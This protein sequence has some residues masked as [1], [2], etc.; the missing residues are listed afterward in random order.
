ME[1]GADGRYLPRHG[2]YQTRLYHIWE[3]M[4]ARCD[5]PSCNGYEYYGAKGISY[6]SRWGSF[7]NFYEDMGPSYR[8]GLSLERV[9]ILGNYT[10]DNCEWVSKKE[11]SYNKSSSVLVTIDGITLCLSQW[12]DKFNLTNSM[13]YKRYARGELGYHLIRPKSVKLIEGSTYNID[14]KETLQ[15]KS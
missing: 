5:R 8:D 13:V 4:K 15:I 2:M 6:C 3:G 14:L 12:R 10:P 9:N 7:E 11:Q 1:R